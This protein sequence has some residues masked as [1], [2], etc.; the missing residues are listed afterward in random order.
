MWKVIV[1]AVVV[2]LIG[3]GGYL[4]YQSSQKKLANPPT[5]TAVTVTQK[6]S[7]SPTPENVK[8]DAYS[9]EVQNGSGIAGEAGRAQ[10]LLEDEDFVIDS[11]GN[12]DN[13]DYT[14][15][16]I[17]A[18]KDVS[19]AW[20]D[21]LK[22]VLKGKYEV[23][24]RVETLDDTDS[25]SDVVVIIGQNDSDGDSM[26]VDEASETPQPTEEATETETPTPSPTES[27]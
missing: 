27:V 14:K 23:K 2:V 18:K 4:Y 25:D 17:Q 20:T 7:A 16:V 3:A 22:E 10:S 1:G 8:K 24:S 15:T 26:V 5:T 9:I 19:K 6:P 11:T 21:Q 13:Y 12:A